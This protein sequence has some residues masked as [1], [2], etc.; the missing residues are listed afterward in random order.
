MPEPP[1]Q[2]E[3]P[4]FIEP[5]ST[6]PPV[7]RPLRP[8]PISRPATGPPTS[9]TGNPRVLATHAP[10]PQYPYAARRANVTGSGVAL[11]RVDVRSGRV[12]EVTMAQSTGSAL[13]DQAVLTTFRR[14][15]FQP[16]TVSR[17]ATPV[18]FTLSG[19]V[20]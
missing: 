16:G 10:R 14:W 7:I 3:E 8:A 4:E 11:L 18:T 15:R 19:V 1:R 17:V 6:P 2:V 12:I 9:Y 20:F 13:L 5:P